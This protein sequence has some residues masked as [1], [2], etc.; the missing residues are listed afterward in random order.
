MWAIEDDEGAEKQNKLGWFDVTQNPL[1]TNMLGVHLLSV[2]FR[3]SYYSVSGLTGVSTVAKACSTGSFE[4]DPQINR[5][6]QCLCQAEG[7]TRWLFFFG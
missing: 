2:F 4:S 1:E 7:E 5:P 6:K 3:I